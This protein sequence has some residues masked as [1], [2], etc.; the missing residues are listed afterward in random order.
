MRSSELFIKRL[1]KSWLY[2]YKVFKS[3]A[4]WTVMLYIIV[5]SLTIFALIYRSWWIDVP[6]WIENVPFFLLF[7]LLYLISWNGNIRTYVEGADKVFLIKKFSLFWGMK[8]WG[9]GYSLLYQAVIT[10]GAISVLL[11][12]LLKHYHFEWKQI[13]A[14]LFYFISLKTGLMLVK[15]QLVKIE[16]RLK[17]I[18]LSIFSFIIMSWLS[19]LIYYL[20][21]KGTWYPIF[22]TG[23]LVMTVSIYLSFRAIK[24]LSSSD[25][26]IDMEQKRKTGNI[27]LI[28][29]M[30]PEIEKPVVS[31]RTK[32]LFFRRSKRIFK[33]RTQSNGFI[34]LF[35]K[36]F[37]RN[38]SY[39]S[40]Y[41]I[42]INV[43]TFAIVLLPPIWIKVTIFSGYLFMMY[44][45][46]SII[47]NKI[48]GSNPLMKKY[49]EHPAFFTAKR[50]VIMVLYIFAILLLL[51]Y[52]FFVLTFTSNFGMI[53]EFS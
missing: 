30:A 21:I 22:I 6:N 43:T 35:T 26:E 33:E 7:F 29:A 47:W 17:K 14:L 23:A 34:E 3:I 42:M 9:F 44:Y 16:T 4:D 32:P 36:V 48:M 19:Q 10:I 25:H 31:K 8:K 15:Y 11:P 49:L 20:W 45:W 40:G 41:L 53:P 28:F 2:Q 12:F 39:V 51:L 52:F 27:Q 18:A 13:A 38:Y 1:L 46:L 50:K 24:K 5:P 37:L